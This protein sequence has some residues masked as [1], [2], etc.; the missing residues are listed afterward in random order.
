MPGNILSSDVTGDLKYL[1][2]DIA[3]GNS[4]SPAVDLKAHRL[5]H[6]MTPAGFDGGEITLQASPDGT[7]WYPVY[8]AA[9]TYKV[10]PAAVAGASRCI[11]VDLPSLFGFQYL[12]F[13][14][15]SNVGAQRTLT[16]GLIPR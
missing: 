2:V 8:D 11:I 16:L 15:A 5:H 7:T 3:N 6:I 1:T 9:A 10:V 14:C 4:L 13:Q 12:K